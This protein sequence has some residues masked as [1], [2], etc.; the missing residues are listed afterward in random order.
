MHTHTH[1]HCTLQQNKLLRFSYLE[2]NLCT[3]WQMLYVQIV[4]RTWYFDYCIYEMV[5]Y[6][7]V[8]FS[9]V[10]RLC[11]NGFLSTLSTLHH[12]CIPHF[13]FFRKKKLRI[14]H[15]GKKSLK[16]FP[17]IWDEDIKTE[18]GGERVKISER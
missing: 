12:I 4:H 10:R 16:N 11:Y 7:G 1:T 9:F 8:C 14:T 15:T 17:L 3:S 18:K 2:F 6:F 5:F 13:A